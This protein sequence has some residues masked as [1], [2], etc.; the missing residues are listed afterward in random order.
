MPTW[1]RRSPPETARIEELCS[2]WIDTGD[3]AVLT[4][5]EREWRQRCF[6]IVTHLPLGR[7]V[8]PG[9]WREKMTGILKGPVPVFGNV[10][11]GWS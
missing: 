11:K 6:S 3:S 7:F 4:G 2:T 9:A 8:P 1:T 10:T 5:I